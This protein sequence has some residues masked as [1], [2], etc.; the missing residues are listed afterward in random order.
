MD[1]KKEV[2]A[3]IVAREWEMFQNVKNIGGRAAC[4]DDYDTFKIHR[5]SQSESWSI[6]TLESYLA[7]LKNADENDRNLLSEK[8]A[9]MM[10][11]TS[12]VEYQQI[13]HLLPPLEEDI[14][15]LIDRILD[16]VLEWER[17]LADKY[18]YLI[19]RSRPIY[20]SQD[21]ADVTSFETYLRGELM[22]YSLGTL[23]QY[24]SDILRQRDEGISGSE[25]VLES[26]VKQYGYASLQQANS[27]IMAQSK[28]ESE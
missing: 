4:Q 13:A 10:A 24:L 5:L 14:P 26:I 19:Q 1:N 8:Y 18:P 22:T 21:T 3:E 11:F 12:P 25:I 6:S 17:E 27:N 9:R 28:A 7:D 16:I 15:A 23:R 2:I 20:A